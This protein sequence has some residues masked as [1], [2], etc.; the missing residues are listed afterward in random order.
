MNAIEP[1]TRRIFR[2]RVTKHFLGVAVALALSI[3]TYLRDSSAPPAE[4]KRVL[5]AKF[6]APNAQ[7]AWSRAV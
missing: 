1:T 3:L 2:R 7:S 4:N 5:Y 6:V